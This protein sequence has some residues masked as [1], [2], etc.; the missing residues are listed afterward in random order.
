MTA[1]S[2]TDPSTWS[3]G[4]AAPWIVGTDLGMQIDYSTIVVGAVWCA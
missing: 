2:Q 3:R 4:A 1:Y